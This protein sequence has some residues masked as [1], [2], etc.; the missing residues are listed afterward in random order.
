MKF[1]FIKNNF[2]IF[3]ILVSFIPVTSQD[4][5]S[6]IKIKRINNLPSDLR[7]NSMLIDEKNT[8]WLASSIGLIETT[9]EGDKI[10]IHFENIEIYDIASDR[11]NDIWASSYNTIYN[12]STKSEYSLPDAKLKISDIAYLKGSIWVGT[13]NGLYQFNIVSSKFK[14][15]NDKNSQLVNNVINFVHADKYKILWIGTNKGYIRMDGEKWELQDKKY[16]MLATC[17]NEEGQWI[18][19][20]EDMFLINRFNRLFPVKLLGNQYS[21]KINSFVLDS[22]GRIY[23]ASDILVKYDP[24][25]EK[26]ENYSDDASILSK[27]CLSLAS[28]KND[29]IWIGTDGSGLYKLLLGDIMKEKLDATCL[30]QSPVKC[31][32]DQN[33]KLKVSASGGKPPYQYLWNTGQTTD[34]ISLLKAGEFSVTVSDQN[35]D[36]VSSEIKLSEPKKLHLEIVENRRVSNPAQPDGAI[37]LLA[38]GG[39]GSYRFNWSNGSVSQNISGLVTGPYTVTVSD[40]NGCILTESYIIKREKYIPDLE[41]T[42]VTIGQRLRINDLNFAADSINIT[43]ENF[44]ILDEVYDF[45]ISNISVIVEIGGHTNTIPPHEYCDLLSYARAK[46]VAEYLFNNGIDPKRVSFKGYGKREPLTDSTSL[47]GRQKNQRVEVK[48]LGL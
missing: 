17:E 1:R 26:I 44:E 2:F 33:G 21:G 18:I 16:L 19:T 48:I 5:S 41:I 37:S 11:M 32:G 25:L 15:F 30:I 27:A 42:K 35:N 22:K 9:N 31:A 23:I 39:N 20:N 28:D 7:I 13:N 29:N 36:V 12:L 47:Q 3:L 34:A 40:K 43:R 10:N 38:S 4:N 24:Y 45:L 46:K 8:L 6:G 14:L